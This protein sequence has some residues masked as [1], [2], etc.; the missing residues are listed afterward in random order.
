MSEGHESIKKYYYIGT[1]NLIKVTIHNSANIIY[2]S[3]TGN[4]ETPAGVLVYYLNFGLY[5]NK[6]LI[7]FHGVNY[8]L[9][10]CMRK[11]SIPIIMFGKFWTN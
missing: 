10:K 4:C 6:E 11:H 5:V 1:Y 3:T 7:A 8:L 2:V 9:S